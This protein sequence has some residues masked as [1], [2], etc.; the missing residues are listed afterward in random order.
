MTADS[1]NRQLSAQPKSISF[2]GNIFNP[3]NINKLSKKALNGIGSEISKDAHQTELQRIRT[4]EPGKIRR[5]NKLSSENL[6]KI[7]DDELMIT[8]PNDISKILHSFNSEDRELATTIMQRLTQFGNMQSLNVIVEKAQKLKHGL[9]YSDNNVSLPSTLAYLSKKGNFQDVQF[10]AF[11]NTVILDAEILH[12][13]KTNPKF[14]SSL[15]QRQS[16]YIYPEGWI[17]GINPFNQNEDIQKVTNNVLINTKQLL[18]ED[19]NIEK[20]EAISRA[21]NKQVVEEMT[22]LGLL[23]DLKIAQNTDALQ[24]K[25]T[26]EQIAA[27]LMPNKV[28]TE[29][30]NKILEQLPTEYRQIALENLCQNI[31]IYSPKKLALKLTNLHKQICPDSNLDGVYF[32]TSK[33]YK[34]YSFMTLNYKIANKIPSDHLITHQD[35]T[36]IKDAKK[37]V[38]IDDLAGSG[39]SLEDEYALIKE[40]SN[41][42]IILAPLVATDKAI[43]KFRQLAVKD[44]KV[45]LV[46]EEELVSFKNQKY[47]NSLSETD[48]MK[49]LKLLQSTG[50]EQNGLNISFAHMAP[51]NNNAFFANMLAKAFTFNAKG[52]K[53]CSN[54]HI[55]ELYKPLPTHK[56][57]IAKLFLS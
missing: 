45:S 46:C 55:E 57:D 28:K 14:L 29:D 17:N 26:A 27:Q 7:I 1:F 37:L 16:Q 43:E 34:S 47:F 30:V 40:R 25:A 9:L 18:N 2:Y 19:V 4:F 41:C 39:E 6:M 24:N 13:M 51:D 32:V 5:K 54:F 49:F 21:I 56:M 38:I 11:F 48:Q 44:P 10:D 50:C 23:G 42:D 33:I 52:S 31:K 20:H 12:K 53:N 36:K 22:S 35:I 15:K 3:N 8:E